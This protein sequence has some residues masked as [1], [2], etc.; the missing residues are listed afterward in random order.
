[1][2]DATLVRVLSWIIYLALITLVVVVFYS[3]TTSFIVAV[4][5]AAGALWMRSET[6]HRSDSHP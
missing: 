4:A 3:P 1:M 2:D 6:K 5:F